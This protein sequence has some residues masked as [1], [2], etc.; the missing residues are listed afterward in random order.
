MSTQPEYTTSKEVAE[1]FEEMHIL[2][3]SLRHE[4]VMPEHALKILFQKNRFRNAIADYESNIDE[5]I[6]ELDDF[7]QSLEKV[8][9]DVDYSLTFSFNWLAFVLP[10]G[11]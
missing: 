8:A 10:L 2:A 4:Y 1:L 3:Y 11:V 6:G 5:I 9:E 7:L